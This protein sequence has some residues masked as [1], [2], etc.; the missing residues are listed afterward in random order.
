MTDIKIVIRIL[1]VTKNSVSLWKASRADFVK[2]RSGARIIFLM[3]QRGI[4]LVMPLLVLSQAT[5][6]NAK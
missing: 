2:S 6:P 3:T 1:F 4:L 5:A